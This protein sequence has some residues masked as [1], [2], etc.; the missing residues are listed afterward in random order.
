MNKNGKPPSL[1]DDRPR[2][3]RFWCGVRTLIHEIIGSDLFQ[4]H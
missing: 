1:P 2:S 3:D 4:T